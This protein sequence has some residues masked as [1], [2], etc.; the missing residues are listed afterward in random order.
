MNKVIIIGR[1]G[2]DPELKYTPSGAAVC[3]LSVATTDRYKNKQGEKVEDTQWHNIVVWQQLAEI[4]G[5]YLKKG[6]RVYLE[7]KRANRS[8]DDRDGVKKYITEIIASNMEMLGDKKETKPQQE[9]Q[10]A[11]PPFDPDD[12]ISF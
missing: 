1:V 7:G 8:Y 3:N 9:Q 6:S 2:K 4:C 12:D 11:A 10:P 5:K